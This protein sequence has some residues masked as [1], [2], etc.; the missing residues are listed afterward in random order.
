MDAD[1]DVGGRVDLLYGTDARFIQALGLE[2]DWQQRGLYQLALPQF[3]AEM[4]SDGWKAR[5]GR[6]YSPFGYESV[7]APA[8]FFYS[9][10]YAFVYGE[11][12]T[13]TGFQ[14][15][16]ELN[17]GFALN[18]GIDHGWDTFRSVGA[19][20]IA[21]VPWP[22]CNGRVRRSGWRWTS[23]SAPARRRSA[24]PR[25][26]TVWWARSRPPSG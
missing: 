6:F 11:P 16:R 1:F 20:T 22:A 21:P 10:S 14:L 4:A 3:Y 18:A 5:A 23:K 19:H 12:V 17:K 15:T 25:F 2:P 24:I 7:P 26:S 8:N 9:H 13:L